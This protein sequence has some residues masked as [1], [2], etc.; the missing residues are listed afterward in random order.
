M[1]DRNEPS[2]RK[3]ERN[4]QEWQIKWLYDLASTLGLKLV[5]FAG[6]HP[7]Q[8]LPRDVIHLTPGHRDMDLLCSVVRNAV[9]FAAPPCGAAE[10]ACI[11]GCDFLALGHLGIGMEDLERMQR[12]RG[13]EFFGPLINAESSKAKQVVE[14]LEAQC[15]R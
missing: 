9:L 4:T 1:F 8:D 6:L 14:F 3:T 2:A 10:V 13:F 11:F 15:C 5:V 7:R 12:G